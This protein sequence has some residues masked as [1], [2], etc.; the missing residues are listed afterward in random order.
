VRQRSTILFLLLFTVVY[1]AVVKSS[2]ADDSSCVNQPY[3]ESSEQEKTKDGLETDS[4]DDVLYWQIAADLCLKWSTCLGGVTV[5]PSSV[6]QVVFLDLL[7]A[8]PPP[9]DFLLFD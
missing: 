5:N 2:V 8:R 3:E 4:E 6:E 1:A 9:V 7:S